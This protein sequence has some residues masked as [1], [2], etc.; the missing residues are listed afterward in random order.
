[1]L[2]LWLSGW[3]MIQFGGGVFGEKPTLFII[4]AVAGSVGLMAASC[5]IDR[6]DRLRTAL[7]WVGKNSLVLLAVHPTVGM[8]RQTWLNTLGSRGLLLSY[9]LEMIVISGCMLILC[10]P[11]HFVIKFP[12]KKL[13][14]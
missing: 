11:L 6:V 4:E 13:V 10:G 3:D 9:V 2:T 12:F 1:M 14:E 7:A 8:A 5:L